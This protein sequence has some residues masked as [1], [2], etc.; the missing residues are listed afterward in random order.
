MKFYDRIK[1]TTV[2]T[3]TGTI[4]LAGAVS[5]FL[6][7]SSQFN[8]NDF[9]MYAIAGQTGTLWEVGLGQLQS[10]TTLARITVFNGSSGVGVLV[11]L[12]SG[13]YDIFC[14][15]PAIHMSRVEPMGHGLA[16]S[17]GYDMP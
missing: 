6:S 1:E 2:T 10:S 7:F 15:I 16:K 4:T 9:V 3:G 8:I 17:L 11:N 14:T 12:T 5:Q 13:T